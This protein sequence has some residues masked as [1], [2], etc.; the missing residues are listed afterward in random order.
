MQYFPILLWKGRSSV[1]KACEKNGLY[2][3]GTTSIT[4]ARKWFA[5]FH[6]DNFQVKDD[7]LVVPSLKL[8]KFLTMSSKIASQL[9]VYQ[10]P[11]LNHYHKAVFK[12]NPKVS[13]F[14]DILKVWYFLMKCN[15]IEPFVKCV[16]IRDEK[17]WWSYIC[18]SKAEKTMVKGWW[19]HEITRT[20]RTGRNL[21]TIIYF[22]TLQ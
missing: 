18:H 20:G 8:M 10:K 5:F 1:L 3:E 11:V 14:S 2:G 16:I 17:P 15:K 9:G 4:A 7:A 21:S 13:H 6:S 22:S 12:R 19:G